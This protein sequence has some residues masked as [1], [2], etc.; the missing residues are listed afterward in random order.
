RRSGGEHVRL[1]RGVV[2]VRQ[3]VPDAAGRDRGHE[4]LE[5]L[6][7]LQGSPQRANVALNLG[8]A[9]P[10]DG[11]RAGRRVQ[12]RFASSTAEKLG[13]LLPLERLW[14]WVSFPL[15]NRQAVLDVRR[16]TN[17]SHLALTHARRA[18]V[19]CPT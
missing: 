4:R 17:P 16:V 10:D 13:K 3:N 6:G 9:P 8:L 19:G 11:A 2:L 18:L 1:V 5:R 12:C 15:E 14:G 7:R